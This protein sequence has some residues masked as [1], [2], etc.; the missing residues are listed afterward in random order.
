[1][2]FLNRELGLGLTFAKTAKLQAQM[3]NNLERFE[4]ARN[5]AKMAVDSARQFKHRI[6][7]AKMRTAFEGRADELDKFIS[8]L[9][10]P[11]KIQT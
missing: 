4:H 7:D 8:A 9:E 3:H 6:T 11:H 1:M 5:H 10:P 2:V